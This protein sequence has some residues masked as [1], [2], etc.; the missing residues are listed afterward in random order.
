MSLYGHAPYGFDHLRNYVVYFGRV[1]SEMRIERIDPTSGD[2][3]SLVRVPLSYS[4][5]DRNLLRM[6]IKPGTPEAEACPPGFLVLPHMG[7]ELTSVVFDPDRNKPIMSK[8]VR[9]DEDDLDKL[10]RTFTLAPYNLGFRLYV[11]SKN[12]TEGNQILEQILPFFK[13]EFTSTLNL[14]PAM[15]IDVDVPI[16]LN[17]ID[18]EDIYQGELTEGRRTVMWTLDFTMK[19]YFVGPVLS[20]PIIKLANT[21]FYVGNTSTTNTVVMKYTVTPGLLANGS[22]TS[23]ADATIPSANIAVDDTF[24]YIVVWEDETD[25]NTSS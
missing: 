22:P 11:M 21:Q 18:Y 7:F 23:N 19:A 9:K 1:F 3:T 14:V 16:I 15:N 13:P 12:I 10:K 17:S 24:G 20:K 25:A 5:R 2:Q 6:S 8:I 4:G